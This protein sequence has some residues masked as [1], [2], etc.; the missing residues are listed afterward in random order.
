MN[1]FKL[2]DPV[3]GKL[4][5]DY[6]AS[7][8]IQRSYDEEWKLNL[9]FLGGDQNVR[10]NRVEQTVD[11]I[12]DF[13]RPGERKR[14][15]PV[16][17][18]IMP[19][20]EIIT[21]K[22]QAYLPKMVAIPTSPDQE[23]VSGARVSTALMDYQR[24]IAK[25]DVH[26][27]NAIDISVAL[28]T[29]CLFGDFNKYAQP[30]VYI[31]EYNE[32]TGETEETMIDGG[33]ISYRALMP[34]QCYPD[35]TALSPQ[36]IKWVDFI[37]P[38]DPE[39]A[40]AYWKKDKKLFPATDDFHK[41]GFTEYQTASPF[42]KIVT[43]GRRRDK[44][45]AMEHHRFD[46]PCV[47]HPNG[48]WIVWTENGVLYEEDRL[49]YGMREFPFY[50]L[51]YRRIPGSVWG[52]GLITGLRQ[53]QMTRNFILG[54]LA[55]RRDLVSCPPLLEPIGSLPPEESETFSGDTGAKIK[56]YPGSGEPHFMQPPPPEPMQEMMIAT[57]DI[58]QN[59]NIPAVM[60]G[61]SPARERVSGVA[62]DSLRAE[63]Q[64]ALGKGMKD[65]IRALEHMGKVGLYIAADKYTEDK[66]FYVLGKQRSQTWF[67]LGSQ[68]PGVPPQNTLSLE[69]FRRQ[70]QSGMDV[71]VEADP[72]I[73]MTRSE[74]RREIISLFQTAGQIP[75]QLW[76]ILFE[77][78]GHTMTEDVIATLG[79]GAFSQQMGQAPPENQIEQ[80][81]MQAQQG[82][83]PP[84]AQDMMNFI[85]QQMG[86]M[87]GQ[88]GQE[89]ME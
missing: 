39:D 68:V 51:T 9:S 59:A 13:Y 84:Q 8:E 49:P 71:A 36:E 26:T 34:W 46:L 65:V 1:V 48:R 62:V 35:P 60:Q 25:L 33:E 83:P 3:I 28:G 20:Y 66:V 61:I 87:G 42:S 86:G 55:E 77:S 11:R 27:S 70:V 15:R 2:P 74:R 31:E 79:R 5:A 7:E 19:R 43:R 56:Y 81:A 37:N 50:W 82:P 80:A 16:H 85:N 64:E 22:L 44:P 10:Y 24:R 58:D 29:T 30:P 41:R 72:G 4:K 67:S 57:G 6:D 40:A 78:L 76:P 47:Q 73:P 32:M 88:G 17:N 52:E 14:R 54:R 45:Q 12:A 75:P 69:A 18:L 63:A 23:D 53:M 89:M 21:S 38:V